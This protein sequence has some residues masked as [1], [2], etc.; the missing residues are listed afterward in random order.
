MFYFLLTQWKNKLE[1]LPLEKHFS[2]AYCL[3]VRLETSLRVTPC[4]VSGLIFK[5]YTG[6][7]ILEKDKQ[8]SLLCLFVSELLKRF[9]NIDLRYY[10]KIYFLL[11]QRQNK[12]ECL[13]LVRHFSLA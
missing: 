6:L 11:M 7:S 5:F 9:C 13:S 3:W 10:K 12:L 8:S 2:L 1:C 4:V